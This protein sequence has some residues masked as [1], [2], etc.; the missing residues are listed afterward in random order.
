MDAIGGKPRLLGKFASVWGKATL[1]MAQLGHSRECDRIKRPSGR[2]RLP[3]PDRPA[4]E[5]P[6]R[7][8]YP[9]GRD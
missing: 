1:D 8:S 3:R 4:Q 7:K 2:R 9:R 5:V 6:P